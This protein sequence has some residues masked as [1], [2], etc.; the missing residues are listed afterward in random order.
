MEPNQSEL[1]ELL[2]TSKTVAVVG[3][4][5]RPERASYGVAKYLERFYNIIPVNPTI[6]SWEGKPAYPSLQA[7][8]E[9]IKI[10]IV[11]VFR[12]SEDVPPVVEDA[13]ARQ[14]PLIWLQQGITNPEAEAKARAQGLTVVSDACL[15]VVHAQVR[16]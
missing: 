9:H 14:V 6:E 3:L 5:P 15:A 16:G 1:A 10:D 8:P 7:I 4:S 2:R 13:L 11:D 12:R